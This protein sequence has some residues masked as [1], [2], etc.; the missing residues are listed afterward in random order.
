MTD[1]CISERIWSS[2]KAGRLRQATADAH[3]AA[4]AHRQ[5]RERYIA[6][7]GTVEDS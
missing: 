3:F 2:Q 6:M 4:I 5:G 1:L 7:F